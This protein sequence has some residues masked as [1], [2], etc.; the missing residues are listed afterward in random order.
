MFRSVLE[1]S[2][3]APDMMVVVNGVETPAWNGETVASVLL[4]VPNA[5]RISPV[6]GKPRLPYCQMGVC[7][8]CLAVVDG[9]AS[10]QGCLVPVKPGMRIDIQ[11]GPR[12]IAR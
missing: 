12:E 1:G 2:A 7:F 3:A 5:G 4:R 9:I 10:T 6:S 8:D 11:R